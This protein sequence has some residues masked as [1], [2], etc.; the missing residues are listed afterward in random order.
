MRKYA[1]YVVANGTDRRVGTVYAHD[2]GH[3]MSMIPDK[4]KSAGKIVLVPIII[5]S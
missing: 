4:H 3:A 2:K 1:V 5:E